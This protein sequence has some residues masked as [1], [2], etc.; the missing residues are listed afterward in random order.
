MDSS[1]FSPAPA[2]RDQFDRDGYLALPGYFSAER[3]DAVIAAL[4]R[5]IEE[6]AGEVV[7]DSL[8]TGQRTFWA[9][10]GNRETRRFKFND[11]YLLSEEV[12]ELSLGLDPLPDV[13]IQGGARNL[14]RAN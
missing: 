6:R 4:T 1:E 5:L 13:G 12:R 8:A 10:A 7:V 11:F 9:D 3:I 2:L 14:K